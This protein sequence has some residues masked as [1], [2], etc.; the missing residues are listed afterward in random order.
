[1]DEL[2]QKINDSLTDLEL[3]I[4]KVPEMKPTM[5]GKQDFITA[6]T[7][8]FAAELA[9]KD[10]EIAELK[11]LLAKES[12]FF[13]RLLKRYEAACRVNTQFATE[14]AEADEEKGALLSRI[15]ELSARNNQL[16]ATRE[17]NHQHWVDVVTLAD[18][19]HQTANLNTPLGR[20]KLITVLNDYKRLLSNLIPQNN[21]QIFNPKDP[22]AACRCIYWK[23]GICCKG[24][25]NISLDKRTA[26]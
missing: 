13:D 16:E 20:S 11:D 5:Q 17:A 15:S 6:L 8:L 2:K 26:F 7:A 18:E 24:T 1:M 4:C 22:T 23:P 12:K 3:A 19:L 14:S 21:I 10:E 9:K 25:G